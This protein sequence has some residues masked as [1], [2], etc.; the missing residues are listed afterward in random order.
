MLVL[1]ILLIYTVL[2][3]LI[4]LKRWCLHI[5]NIVHQHN[6]CCT[7]SVQMTY[8]F[9][10]IILYT[11]K[12]TPFDVLLQYYL[13]IPYLIG[14]TVLHILHSTVSKAILSTI[15]QLKLL[16]WPYISDDWSF[17]SP[18]GRLTPNAITD[19]HSLHISVGENPSGTSLKRSILEIP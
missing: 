11:Q 14:K 6:F 5:F 10:F 3:V 1:L 15:K 12:S 13:L 17:V 4:S 9:S 2:T 8:I 19:L 16:K 18:F 7:F